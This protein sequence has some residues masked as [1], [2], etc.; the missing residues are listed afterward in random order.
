MTPTD[1]KLERY[2]IVALMLLSAIFVA[3]AA[4]LP[5]L[6]VDETRYLTVAWEMRATGNWSLPT[7]NFEPYAHKPPLLFW[8][9]NACWSVFGV[10]VWPAR[11]VGALATGVVLV[12][13][14]R[15]DRQLAPDT[16]RQPAASALMLLALPL[17]PILGVSIM[18]DM[19]L[20][21]TVA[22]AM[23]ALWIAGRNG[24][25]AAFAGYGI[26]IGLGLL[27]KGP[28]V[29]AFT[30]P[31]AL[32]ARYWIDPA[33]QRGWFLRIGFAVGLG[34]AMALAWALRAAYLGGPD[35]AEMLFWKQSAGRITSSFAH[36]RP[37]WFYGPIIL[38]IFAPLL[39]WR[40]A[41]IG[42]R[43]SIAAHDSPR[44]FLL[45]WIIPALLA[46]S[47]ISG[48]QLHYVLPLVPAF[49]LLASLGLRN[50][51]FRRFDFLPPLFLAGGA[52]AALM[53]FA[54]AGHHF[55]PDGSSL[56]EV[57]SELSPALVIFTGACAVGTIA[58]FRGS[59]RTTLIGLAVA[60]FIVLSGVAAQSYK[61]VADVF[62]L[63]PVADVIAP[64]Q[65]RPIAIAQQTRGEFGFLARLRRPLV[66]ALSDEDLSCW[67]KR[68]PN[69]VIIVR[70]KVRRRSEPNI[71]LLGLTVLYRRRYRLSEEITV[72]SAETNRPAATSQND[73]RSSCESSDRAAAS[74][75]N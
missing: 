59:I 44:N 24:G 21:A 48:K 66:H 33:Q 51:T 69:G 73:V 27:A 71:A 11:L 65:E 23:L 29:L 56:L 2:G 49:V 8:L 18:F 50:A 1:L 4:M 12:L 7:L 39:L 37:F 34:V 20:T 74:T 32:L 45:C 31:A 68:H 64:L 70:D 22:G 58:L 57:A 25:R 6:P 54:I 43:T 52:L 30:V 40:P 75:L 10:A 47:L 17:F 26:C 16:S 36:A 19:L 60:N 53:G 15:L 14:H 13:T 72:Y 9:I 35:Y 5:A 61:S 46:L 28:V 3:A 67:I 42:L 62:D 41:W 38:L 55:L 63:Q